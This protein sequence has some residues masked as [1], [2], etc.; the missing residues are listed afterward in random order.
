MIAFK[1][2]YGISMATTIDKLGSNKGW[3]IFGMLH[4]TV[5]PAFSVIGFAMARFDL[6]FGEVGNFPAAIKT[7][8]EWFPKKKTALLPLAFLTPLPV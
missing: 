7:V 2:A 6:G 4:A 5:T 3:S 8:G 1:V